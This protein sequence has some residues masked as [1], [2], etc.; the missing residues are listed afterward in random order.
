MKAQARGGLQDNRGTNQPPR[1]HE[2]RTHASNDAIGEAEIRRP[3]PRP[4]E[5]EQLLL[6]EH[7][8]GDHRPGAA[9]TGEAGDCRQQMEDE[10][11]EVAHATILPR[12]QRAEMLTI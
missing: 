6:E 11:G 4:I 3:F 10:D 5:N 9:G 1:A 12:R 8:F 7:R 2:E